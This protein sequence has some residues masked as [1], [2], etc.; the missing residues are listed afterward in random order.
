LCGGARYRGGD[1]RYGAT[2]GKFQHAL[3]V[4]DFKIV[5]DVAGERLSPQLA[6]RPER[7]RQIGCLHLGLGG[8]PDRRSFRRETGLYFRD[9]R[10]LGNHCVGLDESGKAVGDRRGAERGKIRQN[11]RR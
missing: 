5:Q 9:Q 3:T 8:L 10:R 7:W 11:V 2:G 4:H 1:A 6:K